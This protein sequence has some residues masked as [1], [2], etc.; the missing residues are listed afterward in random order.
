MSAWMLL[1]R[2]RDNGRKAEVSGNQPGVGQRLQAE[3]RRQGLSQADL[4]DE[5][6]SASYISLIESGRREPTDAVLTRLA[7]KLG[8]D[9]DELKLGVSK[10]RS[11]EAG[12]QLA[13]ARMCL[14]Q[15]DPAEAARVLLPVVSEGTLEHEALQAFQAR[16]LLA[17][18]QEK[19]GEFDA[20]VR[21]L[22]YLRAQAEADPLALP[23]LPVLIALSRC[24]REVGDLQRAIDLAEAAVSRCHALE[25]RGTEDHAK[26]VATLAAAYYERG[27]LARAAALL[28]EVLDEAGPSDR[29]ARAAA[30]WNAAV[31]ASERGQPAEA[32]RLAERAAALIAEG[33]DERAA[34]RLKVTR[35]WVM[36]AQDPPMAEQA[37]E[38]L[39]ASLPSIRQHDSAASLGSA[40]TELARSELL[41]GRPDVARRLAERAIKR[42]GDSQPLETARARAAL[43]EAKLATGD[44]PGGNADLLAAGEALATAGA[45]RQ[46]AALWRRIG[47]LRLRG[48]DA[49]QAADAYRQALSAAGFRE[50][51][52]PVAPRRKNTGRARRPTVGAG[53]G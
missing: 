28:D 21:G 39:R 22:E 36:L 10:S 20:A 38:L 2:T 25:L 24:Y 46:A 41:L 32:L 42:L 50:T 11:S 33:G 14:G 1:T 29:G 49:E 35:A 12:M 17:E 15:G 30:S 18:A 43:A 4:A 37:R 8:I 6:I 13:F 44:T 45:H 16:L 5:G 26:L 31:V 47:D 19:L 51:F 27:D 52:G 34:A 9:S 3:R 7:A 40:E 23:W 53:T 48:G